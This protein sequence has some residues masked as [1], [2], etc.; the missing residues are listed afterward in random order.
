MFGQ[1]RIIVRELK[2]SATIVEDELRY[3]KRA[4]ELDPRGT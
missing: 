2:G 1:L 3:S 4:Y